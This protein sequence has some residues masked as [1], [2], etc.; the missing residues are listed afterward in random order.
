MAQRIVRAKR[1]LA[2]AEV[3]F[4]VPERN[5]L[6]ARLDAVLEVIYLIFNEGYA[7]SAGEE[8]IRPELIEEALRLGRILAELLPG[9]P[10]VQGLAALME[11]QASRS[12]ARTGASGEAIPLDQQDRAR[13]D[14]VLIARGKAALAARGPPER[15]APTACRPRSPPAMRTRASPPRPT[16]SGS[17]RSTTASPS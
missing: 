2:A 1:T 4:E 14:W 5:E 3:P 6:P 7:A 17:P 9:E 15:S 11:L 10:E 12:R 8:W 16:G 13:W